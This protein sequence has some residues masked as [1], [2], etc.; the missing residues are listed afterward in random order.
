MFV[1]IRREPIVH[2][3]YPWIIPF[4]VRL[5]GIPLHL[6]TMK[7]LKTI[8]SRL[9]RVDEDKIEVSEGRMLIEIDSRKPLK[10]K[11][12]VEAPEGG[13]VTMEIKYEM[14]FKHCSTC[15]MMTP[16]K[17]HCLLDGVRSQQQDSRGGVFAR[18]QLPEQPV[19]QMEQDSVR[20]TSQGSQRSV[21][22]SERYTELR[23][24]NVRPYAEY[25]SSRQHADTRNRYDVSGHEVSRYRGSN[26]PRFNSHKD[27]II[28]GRDDRFGGAR[29]T[30]AP[31]ARSN[32]IWHEKS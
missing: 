8:G 4:W 25:N 14:L 24:T 31:Y 20:N 22:E 10:F 13:E 32:R 2:D 12:Q 23:N 5:I 28:R 9:G 29:R 19:H 18:V 15:R 1:L 7:N 16:E 27:R 6:W 17:G 3:D 21:Q 30:A 26:A 11:R